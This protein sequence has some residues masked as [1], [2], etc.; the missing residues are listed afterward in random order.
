MR[1]IIYVIEGG[2]SISTDYGARFVDTTFGNK[3]IHRVYVNSE[4]TMY[5]Q[6]EY[7]I[8]KISL[9]DPDIYR[10]YSGEY[11]FF[12]DSSGK[13]FLSKGFISN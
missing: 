2:P 10:Y 7:T 12:V 11:D 5:L 13:I 4:G 1:K 9:T 8:Y 3:P 6:Y